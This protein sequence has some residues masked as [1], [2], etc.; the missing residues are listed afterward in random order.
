MKIAVVGSG[1]SGI[2][3]AWGLKDRA[4]LTLYEASSRLGGHSATVDI[5]YDGTPMSVDTGF[6]VYNTLNYPNLTAFFETLGIATQASEMSF[7]V[8]TPD[9][10]REWAGHSLRSVFATKRN[11]VSPG[12]YWMLREILRFNERC[13]R[14]LADGRIGGGSLNDYLERHRFSQRFSNDYLVPMGAAIWSTPREKVLA[15]PA[16]TFI[17][18]FVNHRLV[19]WARPEWR[20]VTGGSRSYVRRA[21]DDI[22][23]N[24]RAGCKVTRVSRQDGRVLVTDTSGHTD[25]FDHVIIAAHS[26]QALAMLGRPSEAE[27]RILG[28]IRYSSNTVYLHRDPNLMPRRKAVWSSWNYLQETRRPDADVTVSYWMNRLQN[29]DP[30]RPVFVTLN[31]VRP[32]RDDMTFGRFVYDHP[33]LDHPARVAQSDLAQLQGRG[34]IWYSGAYQGDGFHEDGFKAGIAVAEEL[35]GEYAWRRGLDGSG[36]QA[37]EAAE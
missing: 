8:S 6:I 23:A 25:L 26:D 3:A 34:S 17:A 1:I 7:S 4:D 32:P 15:F 28:A 27:Q 29:L 2:S 20:T 11:I 13:R 5:D 10:D 19:N 12:F 22:G 18:F 16:A 31:P 33:L 9:R 14:D 36:V 37:Q 35:G 21:I 24:V 30:D